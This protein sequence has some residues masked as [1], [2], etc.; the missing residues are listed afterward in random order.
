[1]CLHSRSTLS[2]WLLIFGFDNMSLLLTP[3]FWS[4]FRTLTFLYSLIYCILSVPN[5]ILVR[6]LPLCYLA[7]LAKEHFTEWALTV[8]A[9]HDNY[10]IRRYHDNHSAVLATTCKHHTERV[11]FSSQTQTCYV[12]KWESLSDFFMKV[13]LTQKAHQATLPSLVCERL[14]VVQLK[15]PYLSAHLCHV[16]RRH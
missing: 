7:Y 5:F 1:M 15:V 8:K 6:G 14:P 12:I 11:F 3:Y 10:T 13:F 4:T 16:L 2:L 9:C